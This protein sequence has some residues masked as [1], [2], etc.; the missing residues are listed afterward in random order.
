[1]PKDPICGMEGHIKAHGHYFCSQRCIEKYERMHSIKECL[2]CEIKGD[3]LPW[4]KERLYIVSLIT[5]VIVVIAYFFSEKLFDA[6]VDYFKLI[7]WAILLG[8]F[9]G[10][11]IDFLIPNSYISKYLSKHEKKTIFYSVI[12]GFLMSACSHGILAIAMELYKKG[13]SISAVI[14]FLLA[15][16]WANLPIIIL[17]FSFFGAKALLLVI[18]AIVIAIITG[19]IYQVLEK[20]KIIEQSKHIVKIDKSFSI[21]ADI[22]RRWRNYK[23]NY[24]NNIKTLKGVF[25]GSWSLAKMVV[26]WILIGMIL[27]S[28]ARAFVPHE[29]FVKYMGP[30]LLGL[31]V[32][33]VIAT[34]IEVCSEGSAPMAFELFKQTGAFGNSF[35]F[36]MVGV[37]TDYTEIGL[38]WSNIGKKTALWLP[39]IT[40]PQI[41]VLGYLFNT[42]L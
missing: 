15:S 29:F 35:A 23:S 7:W 36:L 42:L 14:A 31:V 22:K 16:P 21:R 17:L 1:M 19:L 2:S 10:G 34:I 8:V 6:F 40:V 32:T 12:F 4:Y 26:W 28:F 37:A 20:K 9:I 18:S 30:T 24:E 39:V 11:V 13:A 33:L 25:R 27:A 41:I 5:V 3:H 38:I